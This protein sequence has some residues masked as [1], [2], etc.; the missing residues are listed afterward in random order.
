[1]V[2]RV[3][4]WDRDSA[5]SHAHPC[6]PPVLIN[7]LAS[8]SYFIHIIFISSI[9]RYWMFLSWLYSARS[10][11]GD[12]NSHFLV[13]SSP[14]S[15][16]PACRKG[17]YRDLEQSRSPVMDIFIAKCQDL[18]TSAGTAHAAVTNPSAAASLGYAHGASARR[19][20]RGAESS[21]AISQAGAT[22][23]PPDQHR[24]VLS[25][26][27]SCGV[28]RTK[29]TSNTARN[30]LCTSG[31][32]RMKTSLLRQESGDHHLLSTLAAR[33]AH[34]ESKESS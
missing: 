17:K 8:R 34:L 6:S 32:M 26:R 18:A 11:S 13:L 4:S 10:I 27:G 15:L 33:L 20:P 5:L 16:C 7:G 2:S 14:D 19:A 23:H 25:W 3:Q 29:F 28:Q 22:S 1:M 24:C 21:S 31:T 9:E 12:L 30:L